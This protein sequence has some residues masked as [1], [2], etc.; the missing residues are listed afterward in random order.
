MK[1]N[2]RTVPRKCTAAEW[3]YVPDM[4]PE[5]NRCLIRAAPVRGV[6]NEKKGEDED[7]NGYTKTGVHFFSLG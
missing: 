3:R 5:L 7:E 4:R 6:K 2:E 1:V